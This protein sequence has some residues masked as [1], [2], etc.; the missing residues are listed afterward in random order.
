MTAVSNLAG[1][2]ALD[3]FF[4]II[5]E[6]VAGLADGEHF[7]DLLAEDVV[8]EYVITVPGYPRRVEGRQAVAGLYRPYGATFCLDRCYD[9]AIHHDQVTGVVVLEYASQG[10]VIATGTAYRN[11]YISVLS[12][13]DRRITH[14]RDYLDP[15]AVF[16]AIGWPAAAKDKD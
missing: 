12:I 13:T 5:K 11:R 9:L 4:A 6:G 10:R 2:R 1:F 8:F 3:P 14:W 16:D 15:L 7:F